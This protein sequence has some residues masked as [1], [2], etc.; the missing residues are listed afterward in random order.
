MSIGV[1]V[2]GEPLLVGGHN[3]LERSLDD[4]A[5]FAP[6]RPSTLPGLDIHALTQAPSDPNITYA[7]VVGAG[8]FRSGDAGDTWEQRAPVGDL[9]PPDIAAAIVM[10]ADPD[11]VLVGSG[12]TG[13]YRS[14]DG[15]ATF[16]LVSDWGTLGL[17]VSE[18]G[19]DLIATTYRGVDR[20]VDGGGRIWE[21]LADPEQFEGQPIA[22]TIDDDGT[23][24]VITEQP[25]VLWRSDDGRSW[26][27][28]ARA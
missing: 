15:G 16:E 9:L 8:L 5:T 2:A 20:S 1:A 3:V 26:Q 4:G 23:I 22:T 6:L 10:P 28:V 17:A 21:N 13:I 24:W 14:E 19:D 18:A 12:S 27:E 11:V 7:F 25:R